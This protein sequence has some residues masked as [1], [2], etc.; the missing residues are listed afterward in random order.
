MSKKEIARQADDFL[1]HTRT[2]T[3]AEWLEGKGFSVENEEMI[4]TSAI[5]RLLSEQ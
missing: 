5:K 3:F 1:K 4:W 2:H